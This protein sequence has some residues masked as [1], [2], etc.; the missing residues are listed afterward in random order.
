MVSDRVF[1]RL[2][3]LDGERV[4]EELFGESRERMR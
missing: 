3:R 2:R 1:R 4:R